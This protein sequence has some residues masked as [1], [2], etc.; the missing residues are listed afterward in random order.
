MR[1]ISPD[2]YG[3]RVAFG[4]AWRRDFAD[5]ALLLSQNFDDR[6]IVV[7]A[8]SSTPPIPA[9]VG[10]SADKARNGM[11]RLETVFL[12]SVRGLDPVQV[13]EITADGRVF[14]SPSW[15]EFLE[16][17]DLDEITQ[18]DVQLSFATVFADGV[19]QLIQP[20]LRA[21]GS[22]VYFLYS[23]RRY[24]F[25]YW[26]EEA[27]RL[28]PEKRERFAKIFAGVTKFRK[29][30]EWTGASL[31]DCWIVGSPLSYRCHPAASPSAPVSRSELYQ[32]LIAD[33]Q[34]LSR[35][36]KKPLCF[37]GVE[38]SGPVDPWRDALKQSGAAEAFLFY[39]NVIK[40]DAFETFDDYL[41]SFRRTTRRAL[42][43]DLKRTQDA[44]I[45]LRILQDIGSRSDS[46]AGMYKETYARHGTSYYHHPAT[47]WK[48]L[49]DKC[50]VTTETAAAF[51]QD[52]LIGFS[53]LL[54]SRRRGEM[55]TYRIGRRAEG[56][57]GEAPY[58]FAL[59]FYTPIRRAIELGFRKIWLGPAG[60]EAKR[61]RGAEQIP[62]F[63]YFWFPRRFDRWTLQRY[64]KL[65][66]RITKKQL[67][68]SM[69][70]PMR[71]PQTVKEEAEA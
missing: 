1:R 67:D 14:A 39:D 61:V 2:F 29:A 71:S 17:L 65:F 23:L 24:Y 18:G 27:V 56:S 63:N 33:L 42:Q 37:L 49:S 26:I 68:F 31:D 41:H 69:D 50:G 22:G 54:E 62:L 51:H 5:P 48:T 20:V 35:S 30:L 70:P 47:F 34:R 12:S 58:Y 59:S 46:F 8:A 36:S 9:D 66:G 28:R 3:I 10:R 53:V 55:W 45:D 7:E 64:L 40:L 57:W 44:G 11:V 19:P 32:Q 21:R 52:E 4:D 60:Y 38:D 25:E 16:S 43:R 15:F 6:A 13:E